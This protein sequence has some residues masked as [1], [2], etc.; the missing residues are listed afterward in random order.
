MQGHSVSGMPPPTPPPQNLEAER[1]VLGA[2]LLEPTIL[3]QV[4][5]GLAAEQFHKDSHRKIYGAIL[6]LFGRNE[7]VDAL[8]VAEELRRNGILE[9]IGGQ[10][11]LATL[12]EEATVATQLPA[13]VEIIREKA[14]R[15][16]LIRES[17]EISRR[18]YAE[19]EP[20]SA[21]INAWLSRLNILITSANGHHRRPEPSVLDATELLC[22]VFPEHPGPV[23]GIIERQTINVVGGAPKLGK[24]ALVKGMLLRRA[25]SQPW[26]GF[27]TTAGRSLLIQ[28]EIP[29]QQMQVRLRLML[30]D[31][32]QPLPPDALYLLTDRSLRLDTPE[33]QQR[34]RDVVERLKPDLLVLDPLARFMTGDE[35]RTPDMGLVI[36][37]LDELIQRF[38]L[39]V[40]VV[41]HTKK[42]G[43]GD[44]SEGGQKLRGSSALFAAADSVLMLDRENKAFTLSL[45]FRHAADP[46]PLI[47]QRTDRLWFEPGEVSKNL[48]AVVNLAANPEKSP[49]Y[50]ELRRDLMQLRGHSKAT[51]SRH[52]ADALELGLVSNDGGVYRARHLTK[53][54]SASE[55]EG[56]AQDV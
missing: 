40:I 44:S 53:S 34:I 15:R 36:G 49:R 11:R 16:A 19:S 55:S 47:L 17:R 24:S 29:D 30:Q 51:A 13:Y 31:V 21:L 23:C 27:E 48:Q 12:V 42:P 3:P 26:L 43:R 39:A 18:C 50:T 4:V 32:D 22:K 45:Q 28:A 46:R 56:S 7:A 9:E 41:H 20:V 6:R 37:F 38:G 14:A 5:E 1:A 33:G 25:M 52:I 10:A 2:I 54:H 8:T 35:N